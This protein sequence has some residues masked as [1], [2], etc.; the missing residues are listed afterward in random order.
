MEYYILEK[1]KKYHFNNFIDKKY[2]VYACLFLFNR[3][4]KMKQKI[5]IS[6]NYGLRQHAE[7]NV[8]NK[9]RNLIKTNKAI[10]ANIMIVRFSKTGKLGLAFP[11]VHCISQISSSN[12]VNI[13][14]VYYSSFDENIIKTD[15]KNILV[16]NYKHISSGYI[17]EKSL[18]C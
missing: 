4:S 2:N 6:K 15:M 7:I 18:K 9:L 13:K 11:C 14:N 16:N 3:G 17:F 5:I 8:I 12:F 1:I 10:K